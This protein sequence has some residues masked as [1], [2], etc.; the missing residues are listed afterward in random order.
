[1]TVDSHPPK[2]ALDWEEPPPPR[3]R[4]YDWAAIA[5][6]LR[7]RPLQWAKVFDHDRASLATAIR[8]KGISALN[9]DDGFEIK[10]SNNVRLRDEDGKE[11]RL[12][13]LYVRY[14]P[15]KKVTKG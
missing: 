10:T 13:T 4:R 2:S 8:I 5:E 6:Q 9:P 3:S 7:A 1:M 15:D 12:C 11:T 14:N